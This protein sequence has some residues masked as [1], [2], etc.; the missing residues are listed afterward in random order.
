M[1]KSIKRL[2]KKEIKNIYSIK[3]GNRSNNVKGGKNINDPDAD[4]LPG[5]ISRFF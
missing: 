2:A 5:W 3:G 4:A 1:K